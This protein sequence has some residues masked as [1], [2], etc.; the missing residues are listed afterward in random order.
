MNREIWQ[1]LLEEKSSTGFSLRAFDLG[2]AQPENP[3]KK[4]TG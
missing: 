4:H 1:A 3:D 2:P